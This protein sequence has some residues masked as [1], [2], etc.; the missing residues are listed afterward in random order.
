MDEILSGFLADY[1]RI[2]PR[3]TEAVL[4][5]A[6]WIGGLGFTAKAVTWAG[7][8]VWTSLRTPV[9]P[10]LASFLKALASEEAQYE[11]RVATREKTNTNSGA[12]K[13]THHRM[14][15]APKVTVTYESDLMGD[16]RLIEIEGAAPL[17]DVLEPREQEKAKRAAIQRRTEV[18][19]RDRVAANLAAA[20]AMTTTTTPAKAV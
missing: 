5:I 14:L 12:E 16:V 2:D 17:L 3:V 19:E 11:E 15:I 20:A 13:V 6:A 10:A 4:A 8:R 7:G 18:I 1:A 9:S